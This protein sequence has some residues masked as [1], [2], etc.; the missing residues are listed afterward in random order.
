MFLGSIFVKLVVSM[1]VFVVLVVYVLLLFDVCGIWFCV[2]I[3]IVE[4][5]AFEGG[6][7]RWRMEEV[8]LELSVGYYWGWN[9][10]RML[11]CT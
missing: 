11:V 5:E 3:F 1:L 10:A 6:G 7:W 9:A 2:S 8:Q 4:K